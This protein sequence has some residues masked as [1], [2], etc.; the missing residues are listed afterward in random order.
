MKIAHEQIWFALPSQSLLPRALRGILAHR[1]FRYPPLV[2]VGR[3]L[4]TVVL[5]AWQQL[6]NSVLINLH[7]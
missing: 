5:P 1:L 2:F 4:A 6:Q 7:S 3:K